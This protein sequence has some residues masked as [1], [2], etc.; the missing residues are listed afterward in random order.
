MPRD[1]ETGRPRTLTRRHLVD[2]LQRKT[3]LAQDECSDHLENV[4]ATIID[5]LDRD[6]R[7]QITRFGSFE[8]REKATRI[9][10]NP[11]TFE[12]VP[13]APRRAVRFRMSGKA[14]ARIERALK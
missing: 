5:R 7:V 12:E 11:K 4:L 2:A 3:G 14:S 6:E 1:A 13:I 10:R 8:V 9:G